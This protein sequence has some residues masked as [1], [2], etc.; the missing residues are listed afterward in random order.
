[1]SSRDDAAMLQLKPVVELDSIVYVTIPIIVN[2]K[3][4]SAKSKLHMHKVKTD[5]T[6]KKEKRVVPILHL[7]AWEAKRKCM[8]SD[9]SAVPKPKSQKKLSIFC[10]VGGVLH[11]SFWFFVCLL[12]QI[13][14]VLENAVWCLRSGIILY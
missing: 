2:H 7:N 6:D 4:N 14:V 12:S 8:S 1:M 13:W 5:D 11:L 9:S 3:P 10:W